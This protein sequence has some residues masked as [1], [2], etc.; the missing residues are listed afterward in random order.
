[1]LLWSNL[2]HA[3]TYLVDHLCDGSG[4]PP[5]MLATDLDEEISDDTYYSYQPDDSGSLS[6]DQFMD[7]SPDIS[8]QPSSTV[9]SQN[10]SGE[11][12]TGTESLSHY[13]TR[14]RKPPTEPSAPWLPVWSLPRLNNT[15]QL[16]M[17]Q[18]SVSY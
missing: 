14:I 17:Q 12:R 18:K 5:D 7:H 3:L 6:D 10:G 8:L 2:N 11:T 16:N 15:N 13:L 1:M 4:V 9:S